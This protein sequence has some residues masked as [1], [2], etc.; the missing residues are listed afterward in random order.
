MTIWSSNWSRPIKPEFFS[1]YLMVCVEAAV[2]MRVQRIQDK[3]RICSWIS[4]VRHIE[5]LNSHYETGKKNTCT[6]LVRNFHN[7]FLPAHVGGF[8]PYP[9]SHL[10]AGRLCSGSFCSRSQWRRIHFPEHF[11]LQRHRPWIRQRIE[12]GTSA[13]CGRWICRGPVSDRFMKCSS[14]FNCYEQQGFMAYCLKEN[15]CT[16]VKN[17]IKQPYR[18]KKIFPFFY[19][20]HQDTWKKTICEVF[21]FQR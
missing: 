18:S 3:W 16:C 1:I 8:C 21:W 20:N 19:S 5:N 17:S 13:K 6:G 2:K 9:W 10:Q 11:R 15:S 4:D 12:Y 14:K 7:L